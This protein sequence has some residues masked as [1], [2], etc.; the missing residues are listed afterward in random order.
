MEGDQMTNIPSDEDFAR[1]KRLDRE[2]NRNLD[3]A[4]KNIYLYLSKL[5]NIHSVHIFP[6]RDL[7]FRACVF[8]NE[9]EDIVACKQNGVIKKLVDFVYEELERS[10]RGSKGEITVAF[11]FDSDENVNRKFGGDYFSRLR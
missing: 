11:E 4:G 3:S 8:F 9:D 10:G 7:G 2:R 5:S 1:A 6:E